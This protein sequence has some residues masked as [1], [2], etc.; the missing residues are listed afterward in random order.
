MNSLDKKKKE[1]KSRNVIGQFKQWNVPKNSSQ[2]VLWKATTSVLQST[3]Y[4]N[5]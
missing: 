5:F 2:C 1:K 4:E 3:R